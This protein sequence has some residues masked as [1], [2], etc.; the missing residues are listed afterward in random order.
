MK[1]MIFAAGI[2]SRLKPLTDERPKALVEIE[3]RPLL[4]YAIKK[5]KSAGINSIVIN[6][7]HF[8]SKI[9]E[10][11]NEN[12]FF[13]IEIIISDET[14]LLLDTGGGLFNAS[15]FFND[16]ESF[17]VYNVDV[18]SNIDLKSLVDAHNSKKALVTLAVMDRKTSRYLLFDESMTLCG[19]RNIQKNLEIV[20]RKDEHTKQYAFSGIQ[21]V[22]PRIFKEYK[23]KTDVFPILDVYLELSKNNKLYGFDHSNTLWFDLGKYSEFDNAIN[24]LKQ[25]ENLK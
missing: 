10:Y 3:G 18:I 15:G 19:W 13:G 12:D 8:S 22:D 25:I 14:N 11:L 7:H 5:L 20:T 9:V 2:G 23:S 1:A 24:V 17:I 4:Y 21:V 16:N 6:V